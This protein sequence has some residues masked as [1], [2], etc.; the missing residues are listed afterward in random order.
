MASAS[1]MAFGLI[2]FSEGSDSV[3]QGIEQKLAQN[4]VSFEQ[5]HWIAIILI[6]VTLPFVFLAMKGGGSP[7]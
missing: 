6:A 2:G 5:T 7:E 4:N 1:L 3:E